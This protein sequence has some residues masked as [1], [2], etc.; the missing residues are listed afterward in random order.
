MTLNILRKKLKLKYLKKGHYFFLK[1]VFK[2]EGVVSLWIVIYG[3]ISLR[4]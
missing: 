2:P 4:K 3:S 1:V